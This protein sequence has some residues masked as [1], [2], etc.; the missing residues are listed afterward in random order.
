MSFLRAQLG[1]R[2]F[3]K[4]LLIEEGRAVAMLSAIGGR[5]AE[6][7]FRFDA[8]A[9]APIEHVAFEA[10]RARAG[11]IGD[12][13]GA[14]FDRVGQ[15]P[16]A[17]VQGVAVIPVEGT[18]I[19][20][21]AW[22]GAYCGDTSYQGL[23]TQIARIEDAAQRGQVRA[24]VLEVDSFGG[25]TD[26]VF[27]LADQVFALS[28]AI[29]TLAI[30]TDNACSA[31]YLIASQARQVIGPQFGQIGSIGALTLHADLTGALAQEGVKVTIL[32]AGTQKARFNSVEPLPEDVAAKVIARNEA[33]RTQFASV[34]AR[35]R[36]RRMTQAQALATQADSFDCVDAI[37][38][39]LVD[40]VANPNDVFD[41]FVAA[42]NAR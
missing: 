26:G 23:S 37:D 38:L 7:G 32:R 27:E 15:S 30:L 42:V 31:A 2:I 10:A 17:I 19:N 22:I 11:V 8:D 34:V 12:P 28:Q 1:G 5:I 39:G 3:G 25:E 35:S 9:A 4:P 41:E 14:E 40:A 24:A 33:I 20:K 29:P 13:L 36:G 21:G 16:F 6:G 18:L